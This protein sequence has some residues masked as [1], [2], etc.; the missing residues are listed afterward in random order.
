MLRGHRKFLLLFA[1]AN[2]GGV[3]AYVPLL[4]LIL[5]ERVS[6]LAGPDKVEWIAAATFF[7]SIAASLGNV[8]FGWASD[9]VG[10]RRGWAAAGL[11]LTILSYVPVYFSDSELEIVAAIIA[12]QLGLNMLLAPLTA[13]AADVVP[14][15]EKGLLGGLIAAGQPMGAIAG[16]IATLPFL[17]N[18]G[19]QLTVVCLLIFAL[20][21]PLLV[22]QRSYRPERFAQP[23]P[24]K[25]AMRFDFGLLWISRFLVQVAGSVLFSFLLYYFQAL[26]KPASQSTVALITAGTLLMAF[27]I[28]LLLGHLS[29]RVGP[30]RPFL[31]AAVLTASV[32]LL[33]M[34]SAQDL[35]QAIAGYAVFG[36]A[37]AV[38]LSLHSAYSMAFLPSPERRGRDLGIL[39]LTNTL[40]SLIAPL[41]AIGLIYGRG[42]SSLLIALAGL[43]AVAA[44]CISFVRTDKR[45]TTE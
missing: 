36:C 15:D 37:A 38:F 30:K 31:I 29:D 23:V 7:G 45:M 6:H 21:F 3:I 17:T 1:L 43:L 11:A 5:P 39:N 14:D 33:I 13:W 8:A 35:Q 22:L 16:V 42:F 24:R 2:A 19:M 32:G 18:D 20:T 34:A 27:P 41:L 25:E 28:A 26:P 40:P 44:A 9:L 12:Y 4:T 10:T